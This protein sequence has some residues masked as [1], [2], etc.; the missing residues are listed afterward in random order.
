MH[1]LTLVA[2]SNTA[3]SHVPRTTITML[4]SK[5]GLKK[6]LRYHVVAAPISPAQM[7]SGVSASTLEGSAL[8]F[9][10][11]G[12]VYRVNG[13]TVL[14]GNI[15]TANATIYIINKVLTPPR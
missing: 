9:S 14:C 5:A 3:F 4:R 13:A 7:A 2:P 6:I 8:R 11:T 1:P 10:R 12:S 15:R